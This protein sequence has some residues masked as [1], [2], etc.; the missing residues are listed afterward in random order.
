MATKCKSICGEH[1]TWHKHFWV[2]A[3]TNGKVV[4][5]R[6]RSLQEAAEEQDRMRSSDAQTIG[7]T[8]CTVSELA[9]WKRCWSKGWKLKTIRDVA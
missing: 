3:V 6:C 4:L 2:Y 9:M 8:T 7:H 5:V 1:R